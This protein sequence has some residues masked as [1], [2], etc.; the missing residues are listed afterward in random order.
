M[1]FPGKIENWVILIDINNMSLF[2]VPLKVSISCFC[3]KKIGFSLIIKDLG[4]SHRLHVQQLPLHSRETFSF[5][6]FNFAFNDVEGD[7]W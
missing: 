7:R 3:F 5:K 4:P 1:F 2:N 6:P